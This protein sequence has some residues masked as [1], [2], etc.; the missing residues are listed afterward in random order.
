MPGMASRILTAI[1]EQPDLRTA[2]STAARVLHEA[3]THANALLE[4]RF[5]ATPLDALPQIR[6]QSD[7]TDAL[8]RAAFNVVRRLHPPSTLTAP[9][10]V[11]VLAVGGYGRA[12]M[13]PFSDVDL[14]LLFPNKITPWGESLVE[15]LLYILWDLKLKVGHS[16]RTVKDCIRLGRE[17][18]TVRTALL[19]HRFVTGDQALA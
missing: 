16:S 5:L 14:L 12:E 6:A 19:E 3:K 7:L 1:D 11:A 15:S 4:A 17:D 18:I 10:R 2:R 8:V 9:E 13:A